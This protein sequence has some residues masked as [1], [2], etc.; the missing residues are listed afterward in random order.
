MVGNSLCLAHHYLT[1]VHCPRILSDNHIRVP[2]AAKRSLVVDGDHV[3]VDVVVV[4]IIDVVIVA[5]RGVVAGPVVG[6]G[7]HTGPEG[8]EEV[9]LG[10]GL[11]WPGRP[12]LAGAPHRGEAIG[13]G[14]QDARAVVELVSLLMPHTKKIF[15][16]S[17]FHTDLESKSICSG[18]QSS[19]L[20]SLEAVQ[21]VG[22]VLGLVGGTG[23]L[24][25]YPDSKNGSCSF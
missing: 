5:V 3:S 10:A 16:F 8:V 1:R 25:P 2:V 15:S 9:E 7:P 18:P 4:V 6:G 11:A 22:L 20:E 17:H 21:E 23:G 19:R 13:R 12:Q 14:V 24:I